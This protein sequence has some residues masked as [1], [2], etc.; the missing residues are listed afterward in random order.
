MKGIHSVS[1]R[2]LNYCVK[3]PHKSAVNSEGLKAVVESAKKK[4]E[5]FPYHSLARLFN[6]NHLL[7]SISRMSSGI[8]K[9][10]Y[11]INICLIKTFSHLYDTVI[12]RFYKCS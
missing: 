9:V 4:Q 1:T 7:T 12:G 6:S 3:I 10:R 2:K 8:G 5:F 11:S